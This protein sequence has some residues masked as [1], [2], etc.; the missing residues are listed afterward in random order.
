[1]CVVSHMVY[2]SVFL[3]RIKCLVYYKNMFLNY[4]AC[5]I[6]FY[7]FSGLRHFQ[8]NWHSRFYFESFEL[9]WKSGRYFKFL[10]TLDNDCQSQNYYS[11]KD[12][13]Y[14]YRK[15]LFLHLYVQTFFLYNQRFVTVAYLSGFFFY[16]S[17]IFVPFFTA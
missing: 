2:R 10:G 11:P 5:K 9:A 6:V 8:H 17:S 16:Q 13:G 12:H 4:M 1:M 14:L 7:M 3:N 15:T